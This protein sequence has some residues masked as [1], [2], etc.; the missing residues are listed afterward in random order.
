M[1]ACFMLTGTINA[2]YDRLMIRICAMMEVFAFRR[3]GVN[4]TGGGGGSV[5]R[6]WTSLS[7]H[8]E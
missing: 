6:S 8:F 2:S 1:T 7:C 4:G 5:V 3:A